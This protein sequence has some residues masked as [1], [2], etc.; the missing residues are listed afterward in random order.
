V[1][2]AGFEL[3]KTHSQRVRIFNVSDV[4]QRL[5]IIPPSTENFKIRH[6]KRQ[7]LPAGI[8]DEIYVQ[9]TPA[10][11]Y[12]LYQDQIRVQCQNDRFVVPLY[13]FPVINGGLKSV[14]PAKID[15]GQFLKV[16]Q[17]YTEVNIFLERFRL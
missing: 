7:T 4:P 2:F 11:E 1:K 3:L 9:F 10:K 15:F 13:A 14:F 8:A 16:D 12:R 6:S 5:L 17:I